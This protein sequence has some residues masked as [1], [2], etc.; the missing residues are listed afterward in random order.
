MHQD[1]LYGKLTFEFQ[2]LLSMQ[3]KITILVSCAEW[4]SFML[5]F[6]LSSDC[7]VPNPS[8]KVFQR[9]PYPPLSSISGLLFFSF[10][11][12]FSLIHEDRLS[13]FSPSSTIFSFPSQLLST[14]WSNN[15]TPQTRKCAKAQPSSQLTL[16]VWGREREREWWWSIASIQ[17]VRSSN[18][19][20]F[21]F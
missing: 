12:M 9:T 18:N 11:I 20:G 13:H 2:A 10:F 19:V 7:P 21:C 4:N 15:K 16:N 5:F 6:A 17:E 1:L 14:T 3:Q 8:F